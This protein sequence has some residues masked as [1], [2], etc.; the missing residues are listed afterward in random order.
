MMRK[1]AVLVMMITLTAITSIAQLPYRAADIPATLKVGANA[2]IR[3][4]ETTVTMLSSDDVVYTVTQA[5]TVLNK[6]GAGY[7]DLV[8]PYNKSLQIKI[9]KGYILDALGNQIARFALSNFVDQSA[10]SN[11]SL[12]E[13][14]RIKYYSPVILSYPFTIVYEYEV[15]S[16]QNLI[17]QDWYANPYPELAVQQSKYTFSYNPLE[18]IRVKAY[19]YTGKIEENQTA[20]LNSLTWAVQN[21]V[22]FRQEPYAPS[23]DDYRTYVKIVHEQF[24]FY[25]AKGKFGNWEELGKWI[26]TDLVKPR[27]DL[28]AGTIAEIRSLVQ[29]LSSDREKAKRIYEYMQR[30]TRYISVQIGIGGFQ[31]MLASDV[32][33][34]GYG[35]CKALVSYMQSLLAAVDIPSYY[36]VVYAGRFKQNMDPSFASMD[37]GNHVILALPLG[38]DTTWLEC[39]NQNVPFGYLGDFTDD[40][41]VL[42]CTEEGGKLLRTPALSSEMNETKRKA[43]LTVDQ[44]GNISANILTT[45]KGAQYDTHEGIIRKPLQEQIKA[46][47]S[48]YE[49]D[50]I[51]FNQLSLT[52]DKGDLPVTTEKLTVEIAS[53][54]S[55]NHQ[56]AYLL[57]NAFNKLPTTRTV[58]NRKLP[59]YINRGFIDEDELVYRLP[60][61]Y[62]IVHQPKDL[63]VE[64]QFGS[65]VTRIS[66]KGDELIYYRKFVLNSGS[67]PAANYTA[68]A[69]F[70]NQVATADRAK[71]IFKTN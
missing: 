32:D 15:R 1:I 67:H 17:I 43:T 23:A 51:N 24:S 8:L 50:N 6:G 19:N 58:S 16:R 70:M 21:M 22:A 37:Q 42:A 30:K 3:N 33:R 46:L 60:A 53:Y 18:K 57:P 13:D 25:R 44:S 39:T 36:C 10:V 38:K 47:N 69:E 71:V 26:Y 48:F 59:V 55:K 34:L 41:L 28:N 62:E 12:Y 7:A 5:I 52:Q 2:V 61:G 31:P 29:G 9:A 65:F 54:L 27:Q 68:F 20:K 64:N 4:K 14:D 40:R 35:D 56:T 66:K 49:V 11:F 45:F 63:K